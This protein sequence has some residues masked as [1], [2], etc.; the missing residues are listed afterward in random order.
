[1]PGVGKVCEREKRAR[2]RDSRRAPARRLQL[3]QGGLVH[4]WENLPPPQPRAGRPRA[5]CEKGSDGVIETRATAEVSSEECDTHNTTKKHPPHATAHAQGRQSQAHT[6]QSAALRRSACAS[7]TGQRQPT[8]VRAW[9]WFLVWLFSEC[10]SLPM[11]PA[12][13]KNVTASNASIKER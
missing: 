1:M 8:G 5:R 13:R 7:E 2:R 10:S 6:R 3:G 11:T 4:T 9:C 12:V